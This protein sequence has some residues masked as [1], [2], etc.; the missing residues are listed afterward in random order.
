MGR[1]LALRFGY[2]V[3]CAALAGCAQTGGSTPPSGAAGSASAVK[4]DAYL[5]FQISGKGYTD[6]TWHGH[7]KDN[8]CSGKVTAWAATGEFYV[9]AKTGKLYTKSPAT[10]SIS[11]SL[12]AHCSKGES[13]PTY[14][15]EGYVFKS[16][17][18]KAADPPSHFSSFDLDG[19]TNLPDVEGTV[20]L[21][22]PACNAKI[23]TSQWREGDDQT[24]IQVDELE[25]KPVIS[26]IGCEP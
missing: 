8:D 18:V 10:I 25:L 19:S 17:E 16:G 12:T 21:T 7:G 23:L 4:P 9:N 20:S 5:P 6:G 15:S 2:V 11:L 24:Y 22:G 1:P 13:G 3:L 14:A 26:Q